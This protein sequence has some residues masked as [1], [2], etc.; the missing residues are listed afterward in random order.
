MRLVNADDFISRFDHV[1]LVQEAIKKAMD[2]MP[3]IEE[4]KKGKW[5]KEGEQMLINLE[6]AREQYKQLGYPHRTEEKLK[7]SVCRMVTLVDSGI[8]YEYCPHC[9]A[10]MRGEA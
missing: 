9:G 3:T 10:D 2:C 8:K 6:T 1:P 4:R 5:T 7:C